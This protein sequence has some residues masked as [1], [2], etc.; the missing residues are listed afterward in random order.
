[1]LVMHTI[2]VY[3]AVVAY[4]MPCD[5]ELISSTLE[6]EES[7]YISGPGSNFHLEFLIAWRPHRWF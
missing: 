2:A 3:L 1:M 5:F 7:V 4:L 6:V